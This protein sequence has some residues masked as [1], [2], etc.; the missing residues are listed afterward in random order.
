MQEN[1]YTIGYSERVSKK[2]LIYFSK[3]KD[4]SNKTKDLLEHEIPKCGRRH[5]IKDI[6]V[7]SDV[8]EFPSDKIRA[9]V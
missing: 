2:I 1:I 3:S 5:E 6:I 9:L 4:M 8:C 7:H